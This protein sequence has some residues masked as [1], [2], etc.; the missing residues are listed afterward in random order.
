MTEPDTHVRITGFLPNRSLSAPIK[1]ATANCEIAYVPA[2]SP[3]VLPLLVKRSNKNGSKGK[4]IVSPSLS[5]SNVKNALIRVE[6]FGFCN[7]GL[8]II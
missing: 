7:E 3:I 8:L 1:G 6:N 5:F 4:T 2:S